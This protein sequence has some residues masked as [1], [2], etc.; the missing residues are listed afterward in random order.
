MRF[1]SLLLS[2]SDNGDKVLIS[3]RQVLIRPKWLQPKRLDRKIRLKISGD[4]RVLICNSIVDQSQFAVRDKENRSISWP[5]I[6]GQPQGNCGSG[7]LFCSLSR[8]FNPPKQFPNAKHP[9][10]ISILRTMH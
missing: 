8:M 10:K 7:E 2:C 9:D 5:L 6:T 4:T 1:L 3:A